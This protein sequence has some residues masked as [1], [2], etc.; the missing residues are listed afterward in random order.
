MDPAIL[1]AIYRLHH[2]E[3][4]SI[5]K[6]AGHLGVS[7]TTVRKYRNGPVARASMPPRASKLDP[8][9]PILRDLL[10][11][12]P[13]APGSVLLQHLRRLGYQGG[14]SILR[15]YLARVRPR[16]PARAFLRMDPQPGE[17]FEVDW[18]H[19]GGL[20]YEGDR[21][22][23]YA[24]VLVDCTAGSCTSSSLTARAS[25]L[26]CAVISMPSGRTGVSVGNLV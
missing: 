22:K 9:K 4:W 1:D 7:R 10:E 25:K 15:D 17:R 13:R 16:R 3:H 2:G 12:D 24:F 19:F 6:I 11:R 18:G 23:L 21:R 14:V 20:E 8:F 5:R 26:L